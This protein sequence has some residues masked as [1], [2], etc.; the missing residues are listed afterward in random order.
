V[1]RNGGKLKSR[2]A[3]TPFVFPRACKPGAGKLICPTGQISLIDFRG[4]ADS[5]GTL[6]Q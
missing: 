2:C 3:G 1:F 6:R 5:R 4:Q